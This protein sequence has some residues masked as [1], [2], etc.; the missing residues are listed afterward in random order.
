MAL[1]VSHS[2]PAESSGTVKDGESI[3]SRNPSK[4]SNA[5]G[6]SR[7]RTLTHSSWFSA[8]IG[9]IVCV[10]LPVSYFAMAQIKFNGSYSIYDELSHMSYAWSASH[11][12]IPAQGDTDEA[13][14]LHDWACSGQDGIEFTRCDVKAAVKAYPYEQQYNYFHPPV[15]YWITGGVARMVSQAVP[16]VSFMVAARAFSIV[17]MVAGNIMMAIALRAWGVRRRYAYS[18]VAMIPFIPAFLNAGTAVTNDAPALLIGSML[19]WALAKVVVHHQKMY[20]P[21]AIISLLT[22]FIKGTFVFPFCA[23][24]AFFVLRG[25]WYWLRKH[26]TAGWKSIIQGLCLGIPG[27]IAMQVFNHFQS[28]RGHTVSSAVM[29]VN[30]VPLDAPVLRIL[31]SVMDW[32]QLAS[33]IGVRSNMGT[34]VGHIMW[35]VLIQI[36][37]LGAIAFLYLVIDRAAASDAPYRTLA[38]LTALALC[39]Y[40]VLIQTRE[41]LSSGRLFPAVG[42]RYGLACLPLV[43]CCWA[44]MMQHKDM[45]RT[46]IVI[47]VLGV[48]LSFYGLATTA[49]LGFAA[50]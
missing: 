32:G 46:A 12:H 21:L 22:G 33:D 27:L 34:R 47:P 25:C 45:R 16:S 43:L 26:D 48:L 13:V 2:S 50:A 5:S 30:T 14:V 37:I 1:D 9:I 38:T 19:L 7:V 15:Y 31:T 8:L 35:S 40:P 17:W 3:V 29:G 36:I 4:D 24:A 18:T 28:G 44:V 23:A 49:A 42:F 6:A 39:L 20:V 10:I 11:G 41:F